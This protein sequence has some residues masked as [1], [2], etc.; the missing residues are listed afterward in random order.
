MVWRSRDDLDD[1]V[2]RLDGKTFSEHA[3][4][5]AMQLFDREVVRN[6]AVD[7]DRLDGDFDGK[8]G[9]VLPAMHALKDRERLLTRLEE[10]LHRG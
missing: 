3:D 7:R 9:P 1:P 2:E 5:D 10:C 4:E 6:R 8:R